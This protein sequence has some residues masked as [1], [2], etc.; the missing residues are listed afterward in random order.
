MTDVLLF[1]SGIDSLIAWFYMN[2]PKAIYLDLKTKYSYKEKQTIIK[3]KKLIPDFECEIIEN[4]DLGQFEI[5]NKAYIPHRNL[6]ISAIASNYGD[7]II[8]AGIED[9]NVE[10]KNPEA[11]KKMTECLNFI[12]KPDKIIEIYSPFWNM[13]KS[14]II[15]WML[16]NVSNAKKI[17]RTSVSC[18]SMTTNQCGQ[19]PSCLRKAIAFEACGLKID[20]FENDIRNYI[21]IKDYIVKM[22]GKN[23]YSQK[24]IDETLNVFK[25]WGY[26]I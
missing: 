16:K 9:D 7:R 11:F 2:K 26:I 3:L 23:N 8:L 17:L 13:S 14:E 22:K 21:D 10:D 19:C 18:Y 20:F 25:K 24:R 4:I 1:S 12:S 15:K 5:G 6:I